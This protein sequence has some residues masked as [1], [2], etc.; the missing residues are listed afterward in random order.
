MTLKLH[1]GNPQVRE[2]ADRVR[3]GQ[4]KA[5]LKAVLLADCIDS[6]SVLA[7]DWWT[8]N[9][10][11]AKWLQCRETLQAQLEM[12]KSEYTRSKATFSTRTA[13]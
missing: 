10:R 1:E 7:F 6:P 3:L 5:E 8:L 13:S 2:Q 12:V 9:P 4:P 11:Q